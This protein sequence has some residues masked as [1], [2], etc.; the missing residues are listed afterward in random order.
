MPVIRGMEPER[1]R[2][3]LDSIRQTQEIKAK[4]GKRK[5][6]RVGTGPCIEP[7][8]VNPE[9]AKGLCYNCYLKM[10]RRKKRRPWDG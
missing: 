7:D 6:R 2:E 3:A 1:V 4:V 8:C 10:Y 5:V 9:H